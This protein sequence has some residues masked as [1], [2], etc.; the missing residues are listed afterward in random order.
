MQLAPTST[1]PNAPAAAPAVPNDFGGLPDPLA[2][3]VKRDAI[4]TVTGQWKGAPARGEQV[5]IEFG[6]GH[7]GRSIDLVL[8][9]R[10]RLYYEAAD[11]AVRA[12][13]ILSEGSFLGAVSLSSANFIG[14]E[15][16]K[17][18]TGDVMGGGSTPVPYEFES[19]AQSSAGRR[20][21]ERT[22]KLGLSDWAIVDGDWA[23]VREDEAGNVRV[24]ATKDY[25]REL[26]GGS[27]TA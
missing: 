6:R 3:V 25:V 2:N 22:L 17:V 10:N 18:G 26:R 7:M 20:Q 5:G 23:A 27:P 11:H 4:G 1:I 19:L 24:V 8:T 12:A 16:R 13:A 15:L 14:T 21:L 9:Q